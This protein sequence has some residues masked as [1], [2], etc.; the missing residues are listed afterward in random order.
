[1]DQDVALGVAFAVTQADLPYLR[2]NLRLG[3]YPGI[4]RLHRMQKGGGIG[5]Q[6]RHPLAWGV[7]DYVDGQ[8]A[9]INSARGI[10]REWN[11]LDKAGMWLRGQG[12]SYWWTRN[13]LEVVGDISPVVG[14]E[15][16]VLEA[17]PDKPI[18]PSAKFGLK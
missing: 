2:Q 15:P 7:L 17:L 13:D 11:D 16:E 10:G 14:S 5:D 6:S 1:M 4:Y 9:R 18:L 8:L 3:D 12:F